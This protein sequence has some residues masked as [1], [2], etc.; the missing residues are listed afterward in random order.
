[1]KICNICKQAKPFSKFHR[2][3]RTKDG[4]L[5]RC[6]DCVRLEKEKRAKTFASENPARL[7]KICTKCKIIKPLLDFQRKWGTR[8]GLSCQCKSCK[9][10][11]YY[12]NHLSMRRKSRARCM[13]RKF[14]ISPAQFEEKLAQQGGKCAACGKIPS[15]AR[16]PHIDH[17]HRTGKVRGILCHG[18]NVSLGMLR[19]DVD[20][21][22][23]LAAYLKSHL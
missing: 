23:K 4:L 8:D 15:D 11:F 13:F 18:C 16:R 9:R 12:K 6:R 19:D 21:I 2:R 22:L 10:D 20:T 14:G 1:M 3:S 17:D 5:H 7:N